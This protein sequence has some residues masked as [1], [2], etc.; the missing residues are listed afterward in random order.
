MIKGKGRTACNGV[1]FGTIVEIESPKESSTLE[2]AFLPVNKEL[3]LFEKGLSI[4]AEELDML[5]EKTRQDV[6][7]EEAEILGIQRMML[8]DPDISDAIRE[9]I[10]GG[11][12]SAAKACLEIGIK[13]AREFEAL[14]D[15]YMKARAADV[16]DVTSR[17]SRAI[18][19]KNTVELTKPSIIVA[20][21]LTPSQ[22]VSFDRK[23]ILGFVLRKGT[24][25]SHASILA[26][27]MNIP[28]LINTE[29]PNE[30]L[31][32]RTIAVD[33]DKQEFI[34][35]PDQNIISEI[36]A[37]KEKFYERQLQLLKLR[38]KETRAPCGH[39]IIA[40]ANIGSPDDVEMALENDAEGIGLFR[41][42]FLYIGKPTYPSE[43]EQYRAYAKVVSTMSPRPVIIR[44]LD[45]G[46]D[47]K[48]DYFNLPKEENPALGFRAI[49]ICLTRIEIFKT[50]L[51]A[52][53]RAAARGNLLVMFPMITS[54]E[55]VRRCKEICDEVAKEL[56]EKN[57]EYKYPKIGIMIE[58]PAAVLIADKL[59]KEVSFFSVGTNDLMQYTCALDRQNQHLSAFYNPHH[60]ALLIALEMIAKAAHNNNIFCGI[61]GE[62][63]A[64]PELTDKFIE[65]G[66]DELSVTPSSI[67]PLRERVLKSSS[68]C[69]NPFNG[70]M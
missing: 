9:L 21:D 63:G 53:F 70:T 45:I 49:R 26:R 47:K 20:E 55:E 58:T 42:E 22:T 25:N 27:T 57:I 60:E 35:D 12:I 24:M 64:D 67:L 16:K 29:L 36:I 17:I 34:L 68:Q 3:E 15:D 66:F 1:T 44:T 4:A 37:A 23:L 19:G 18:L 69:K 41:S 13:N 51:R 39:K 46:A 61:C 11:T 43:D 56:S 54:V 65:M 33:A 32:G 31:T 7:E 40:A 10:K 62:L 28:S 5:E 52:L 38:G 59:A 2:D 6:G 30:N 50:Q 8:D 14:D 48:C